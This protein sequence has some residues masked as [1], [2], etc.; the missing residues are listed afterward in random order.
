MKRLQAAG[1]SVETH[2]VQDLETVEARR[3][4]PPS[5]RSCHTAIVGGYVVEGHVPATVV[6]RLLREQPD[7]VGIAVAGMPAGSP[8]MEAPNPI[9]YDVVAWSASGQTRVY[10]KVERDGTTRY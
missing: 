6:Q 1:L 7:I 4:V 9:P 2:V 10:A 8:G 5:L 3:K